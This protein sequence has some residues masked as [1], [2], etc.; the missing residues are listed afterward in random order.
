[1]TLDP[2]LLLL[3][4]MA[5]GLFLVASAMKKARDPAAFRVALSAYRLVPAG[6]TFA[7]AAGLTVL[8]L[9]VGVAVLAAPTEAVARF[10]FGAIASLLASYAVVLAVKLMRGERDIDCGCL[11]WGAPSRGLRWSMVARNLALASLA[12]APAVLPRVARDLSGVDLLTVAAGLAVATVLYLAVD[13]LI[14][15]PSRRTAA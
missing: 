5:F 2:V 1:M 9:V 6:W 10:A 13:T 14:G 3:T 4:R 8:E 7:G 15:L 12:A 11:G